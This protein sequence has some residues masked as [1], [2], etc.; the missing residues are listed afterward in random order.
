MR[1]TRRPH[2]GCCQ[3]AGGCVRDAVGLFAIVRDRG[4]VDL[5]ADAVAKDEDIGKDR[6]YRQPADHWPPKRRRKSRHLPRSKVQSP[7]VA[8][9]NAVGATGHSAWPSRRRPCIPQQP[10]RES[11]S[12]ISRT[13]PAIDRRRCLLCVQNF[14]FKAI[15]SY[16]QVVRAIPS[17]TISTSSM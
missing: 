15:S 1:P 14:L 13:K 12:A 2:S 4:P 10:E 16:S 17:I 7:L 8:L 11:Q 6:L 9:N 5:L 3:R